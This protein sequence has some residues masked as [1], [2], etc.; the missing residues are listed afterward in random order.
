[1]FHPVALRI[2]SGRARPLRLDVYRL[3]PNWKWAIRFGRMTWL[4]LAV[5]FH[6]VFVT[7]VAVAGIP[8]GLVIKPSL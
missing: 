2:S 1:M 8:P 3:I 4:S 6:A 7:V 5:A